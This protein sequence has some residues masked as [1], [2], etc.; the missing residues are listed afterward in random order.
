M[1]TTPAE[2]AALPTAPTVS[3]ALIDATRYTDAGLIDALCKA[4]YGSTNPSDYAAVVSPEHVLSWGIA[5]V[6]AARTIDPAVSA[7]W[8]DASWDAV[9]LADAVERAHRVA[10]GWADER[11]PGEVAYL[12]RTAAADVGAAE[13]AA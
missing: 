4:V 6:A 1:N 12:L 9:R 13:R 10:T 11:S 8:P 5:L 2:L 3:R 7:S